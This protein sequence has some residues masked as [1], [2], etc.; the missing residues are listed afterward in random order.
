[1]LVCRDRERRKKI[2]SIKGISVM[3]EKTVLALLNY[4]ERDIQIKLIR[5]E[6]ITFR[7]LWILRR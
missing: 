1:M 4:I 3:T 5:R 2:L 6:K 7:F